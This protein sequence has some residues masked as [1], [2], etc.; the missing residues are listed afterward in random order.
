[1]G[2]HVHKLYYS[3]KKNSQKIKGSF[4]GAAGGKKNTTLSLN[5]LIQQHIT[6]P[7]NPFKKTQLT[8]FVNFT[9]NISNVIKYF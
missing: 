5:T 6:I 4:I 1:M 3:L 7:K 8:H 9:F 2:L